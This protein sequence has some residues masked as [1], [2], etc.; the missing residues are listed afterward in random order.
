MLIESVSE[1]VVWL[2]S[3][4]ETQSSGLRKVSQKE[5]GRL[6]GAFTKKSESQAESA[7][8]LV[9]ITRYTFTTE[10]VSDITYGDILMRQDGS[11]LRVVS[12][13]STPPKVRGSILRINQYL[14]EETDYDGRNGNT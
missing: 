2:R 5:M 12:Q 6:R 11:R 13:K 1:Q 4:V 9:P 7:G 14:T 3:T 8:A 10:S